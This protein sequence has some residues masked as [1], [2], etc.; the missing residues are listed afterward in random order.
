VQEKKQEIVGFES[1]HFHLQENWQRQN[2]EG[3]VSPSG[4][5]PLKT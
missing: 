4:F 3:V 5:A 1:N 2:N